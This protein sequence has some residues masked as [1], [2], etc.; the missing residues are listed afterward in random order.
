MSALNL[1]SDIP[2]RL[3]FE[4]IIFLELSLSCRVLFSG[5]F[6][7]KEIRVCVRVFLWRRHEARLFIGFSI[8]EPWLMPG[9]FV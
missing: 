8:L 9:F 2:V 7:F 4:P 5:N 1:I 3:L 6:Q